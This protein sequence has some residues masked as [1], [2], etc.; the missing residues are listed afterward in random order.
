MVGLFCLVRYVWAIRMFGQSD[1]VVA[2]LSLKQSVPLG[3]VEFL[4][5]QAVVAKSRAIPLPKMDESKW[6]WAS[7]WATVYALGGVFNPNGVLTIAWSHPTQF[8]R[9]LGRSHGVLV[10]HAVSWSF[11]RCLGRSRGALVVHSTACGLWAGVCVR[12][13]NWC[14][15]RILFRRN[16]E[17]YSRSDHKK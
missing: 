3:N 15:S 17:Q 10:V 4:G 12:G 6:C 11:T 1:F 9:C 14:R 16:R 13:S 2:G 8:T 5:C 7:V